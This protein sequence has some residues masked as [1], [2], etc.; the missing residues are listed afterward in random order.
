MSQI[1]T[2]K[3]SKI[4]NHKSGS[5][6]QR[7][8]SGQVRFKECSCLTAFAAHCPCVCEEA[9]VI[10]TLASWRHY[11]IVA[12]V[13]KVSEDSSKPVMVPSTDLDND[14]I[15]GNVNIYTESV[16]GNGDDVICLRNCNFWGLEEWLNSF[17]ID[18]ELKERNRHLM[19]SSL[20][21]RYR[22]NLY[23]IC[24]YPVCCVRY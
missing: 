13:V 22:G 21:T 16:T 14:Q 7:K 3:S 24:I 9:D 18:T 8:H 20:K 2:S 11:V 19:N 10:N 12:L 17:T 6:L 5:Q 23:H 4:V 15:P 1:E